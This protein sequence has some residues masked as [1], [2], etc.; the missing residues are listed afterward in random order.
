MILHYLET[1]KKIHKTLNYS[2]ILENIN[3]LVTKINEFN[4]FC[5]VFTTN[6]LLRISTNKLLRVFL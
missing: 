3:I 4:I 2:V 1:N 6:Q 5:S